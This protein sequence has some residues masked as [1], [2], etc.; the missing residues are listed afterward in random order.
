[1]QIIQFAGFCFRLIPISSFHV[2]VIPPVSNPITQAESMQKQKGKDDIRFEITYPD[3]ITLRIKTD[4]D[5]SCLRAL[6]SLSLQTINCMVSLAYY[7]FERYTL[8]KILSKIIS[9][10]YNTIFPK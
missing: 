5:L 3:G 8:G 7:W 10:L 4:L 6:I 2:K 9:T 1:M